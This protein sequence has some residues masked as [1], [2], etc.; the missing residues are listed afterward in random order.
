MLNQVVLMGRLTRDPELRH[1]QSGLPV[2]SFSIAVDRDF[3]QKDGEKQTDFIDIV[4]WRGTA[5]FVS[6]Y[7]AK[8]R[9]AVVSGRLQI[10]DWTDKEGNRRRTAEVVADTC[11]SVTA[12][13]TAA[14][15]GRAT[16]A[17][18]MAAI[19]AM[20]LPPATMPRVTV[21]PPAAPMSPATVPMHPVLRFPS[22]PRMTVTCRSDGSAAKAA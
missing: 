16:A 12:S 14:T 9:M 13:V 3:G 11:I 19:R 7:F 8:G 18:L 17:S 21:S 20:A 4:A 22:S 6:K 10:R 1:T 5:E 2:V 15:R